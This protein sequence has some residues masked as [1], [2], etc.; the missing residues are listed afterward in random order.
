[1]LNKEG[2]GVWRGFFNPSRILKLWSIVSWVAS[3]E[4]FSDVYHPSPALPLL[5]GHWT[6]NVCLL[7]QDSS[8]KSPAPFHYH[9]AQHGGKSICSLVCSREASFPLETPVWQ[10]VSLFRCSFSGGDN[11]RLPQK[12]LMLQFSNECSVYSLN[13]LWLSL[14]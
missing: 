2:I 14:T 11:L 10:P 6:S 4:T 9:T 3:V 13:R 5:P 12:Y 8:A 1:M 7:C